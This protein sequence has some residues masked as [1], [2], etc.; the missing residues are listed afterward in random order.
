M[1]EAQ[2]VAEFADGDHCCNELEALKSLKGFHGGAQLPG[3]KQISADRGI[4]HIDRNP[5]FFAISSG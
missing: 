3:F 4:R 2:D 5:R 1:I